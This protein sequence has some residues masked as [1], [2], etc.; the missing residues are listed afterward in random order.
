K[1][2]HRA[3]HKGVIRS[4]HDLSEGG[5]GVALAEMCLAGNLGAQIKISE[6]VS[7]AASLFSES[8]SRWLIEVEP[9][10]LSQVKEIFSGTAA[11]ELG[12]V[13]KQPALNVEAKK[14]ILRMPVSEINQDWHSFSDRQ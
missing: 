2:L 1:S 10:H 4:C 5:L 12:R 14:K 7:S 11:V 9:K 3:I 8:A 13:Q 6:H